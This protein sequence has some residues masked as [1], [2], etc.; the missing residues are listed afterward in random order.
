MRVDCTRIVG[1]K[2]LYLYIHTDMLEKLSSQ[3]V[4]LHRILFRGTYAIFW[5]APTIMMFKS[6]ILATAKQKYESASRQ[7]SVTRRTSCSNTA[8]SKA[9]ACSAILDVVNQLEP[10]SQ[11]GI[12]ADCWMYSSLGE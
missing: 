5:P 3:A 12:H 6:E 2:S 10:F 8:A 7:I 4:L 9:R 11:L 1:E